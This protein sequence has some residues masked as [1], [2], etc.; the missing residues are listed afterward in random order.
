MSGMERSVVIGWVLAG[1]CL[2][3]GTLA[4]QQP[5]AP[6]TLPAQDGIYNNSVRYA[7][8]QSI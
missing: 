2:G 3:I 1:L 7:R 5:A 8:G 4:A 6:A